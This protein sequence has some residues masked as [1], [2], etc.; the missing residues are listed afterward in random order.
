MDKIIIG[1]GT[2]KEQRF[3]RKIGMALFWVFTMIYII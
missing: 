1:N 2:P 3:W